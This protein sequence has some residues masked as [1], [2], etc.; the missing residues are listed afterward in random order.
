MLDKVK[1]N[2]YLLHKKSGLNGVARKVIIDQLDSLPDFKLK[3]NIYYI[4]MNNWLCGLTREMQS[5]GERG[6]NLEFFK[7]RR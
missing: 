5:L 2:E 7:Q 4:G 3:R 6:R 1:M